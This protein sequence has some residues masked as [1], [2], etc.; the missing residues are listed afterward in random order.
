[1]RQ[2]KTVYMFSSRSLSH[3]PHPTYH[4]QPMALISDAGTPGISDPGAMLV[5]AAVQAGV[6]VVPL[7]GAC[8]FV[9]ALTASGL[10]TSN[11]TFVGFLPPKSGWYWRIMGFVSCQAATWARAVGS[12]W[13][14]CCS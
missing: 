5:A 8:A 6:R 12:G 4:S 13:R 10:D 14:L 11:F 3:T 9:A 1:M 2:G 7:P